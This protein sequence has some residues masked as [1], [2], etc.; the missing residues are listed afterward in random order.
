MQTN[1]GKLLA[2]LMAMR[3]QQYD[4]GHQG[5]TWSH[6]MLL[7]GKHLCRIAPAAAN[8]IDFGRKHKNTNKTQLLVS[9]LTVDQS[10]KS[11]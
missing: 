7:L 3:M 10:Q 5:F 8:V 1:A 4:A 9:W 2:I 6:W 11:H